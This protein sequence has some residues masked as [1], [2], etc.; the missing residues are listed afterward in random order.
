MRKLIRQKETSKTQRRCDMMSTNTTFTD[1]DRRTI[2]TN[3]VGCSLGLVD[4][5][6]VEFVKPQIYAAIVD[7]TNRNDILPFIVVTPCCATG[8]HR[9]LVIGT[10]IV[11]TSSSSTML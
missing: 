9:R 6:N 11:S 7:E 4:I 1:H 2:A 5:D 8:Q 10:W 3:I